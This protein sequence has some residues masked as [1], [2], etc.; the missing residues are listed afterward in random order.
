MGGPT[1]ETAIRN[2]SRFR[3][4]L[5]SRFL[6]AGLD[7]SIVLKINTVWFLA[8]S[9]NATKRWSAKVSDKRGSAMSDG[10][11]FG[12]RS[13]VSGSFGTRHLDLQAYIQHP[14]C[15]FNDAS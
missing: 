7:I 5:T 10:L 11:S 1:R 15:Q 4:P 2:P 14:I 3:N 9:L 6:L 8:D 12:S 13:V